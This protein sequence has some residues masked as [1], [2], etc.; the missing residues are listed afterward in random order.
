MPPVLIAAVIIVVVGIAWIAIWSI[1]QFRR[2]RIISAFAIR[3]S[4]KAV[5]TLMSDARNAPLWR[6]E[7]E[8]VELLTPEPIGPG[9]RFHVR[10][11]IPPHGGMF[12]GVEEIIEYQPPR[13]FTGRVSSG[14]QPNFDEFTFDVVEGGTRV[15]QRFDFEYSFRMAARGALF[16]QPGKTRLILAL[17]R[18]AERR[19]KLILESDGTDSVGPS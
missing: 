15:T 5:F 12:D 6:H 19:L 14:V 16:S 7:Y 3:C 8:S 13:R 18:A 2:T 1:P 4:Q 11:R 9:S 17:R 10:A